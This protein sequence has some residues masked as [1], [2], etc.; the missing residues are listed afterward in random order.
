MTV[1]EWAAELLRYAADRLH[2]ATAP[3]YLGFSFTFEEGTGLVFRD[4]G[5][6]CPLTYPGQDAYGRAHTESGLSV[7]PAGTAPGTTAGGTVWLPRR[8][9]P[10]DEPWPGYAAQPPAR[11]RRF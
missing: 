1:R 2:P 6:G 10:L 11:P 9:W 3:R 4:D 7:S 5:R 8:A